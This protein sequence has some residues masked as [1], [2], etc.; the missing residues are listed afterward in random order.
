[1]LDFATY[2]GAGIGSSIYGIVI[3]Y[4]GYSPMYISWVLISFISLIIIGIIIQK[5]KSAQ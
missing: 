5:N 4:F 3:K 2:G 1:M